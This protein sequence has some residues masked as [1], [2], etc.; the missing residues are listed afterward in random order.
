[1]LLR[2]DGAT[3]WRYILIRSDKLLNRYGYC[4]LLRKQQIVAS[5]GD[6]SLRSSRVATY[7]FTKVFFICTLLLLM[8]TFTFKVGRDVDTS[9]RSNKLLPRTIKTFLHRAQFL[10]NISFTF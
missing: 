6:I 2:K 7:Y 3:L 9:L 5:Y 10:D 1:M 8:F 4:L